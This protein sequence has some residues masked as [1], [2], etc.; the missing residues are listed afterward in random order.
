[1]CA[2]CLHVIHYKY[3]KNIHIL[4]PSLCNVDFNWTT[5]PG[6]ATIIYRLVALDIDNLCFKDDISRG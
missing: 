5:Q 6:S 2:T 4:P 3:T 1:V